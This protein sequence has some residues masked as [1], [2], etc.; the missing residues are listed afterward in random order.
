MRSKR[1]IVGYWMLHCGIS[2]LFHL[3]PFC[4]MEHFATNFQF[5]QGSSIVVFSFS[6]KIL[7]SDVCT[8]L[9]LDFSPLTHDLPPFVAFGTEHKLGSTAEN[10]IEAL[11]LRLARRNFRTITKITRR[12]FHFSIDAAPFSKNSAKN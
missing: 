1:C 12:I 8:S 10:Y 6:I 5:Y 11:H 9:K 4:K 7:F 2:R 3:A